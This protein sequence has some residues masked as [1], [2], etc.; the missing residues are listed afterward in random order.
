MAY[1]RQ[2]TGTYTNAILTI[3]FVLIVSLI[4]PLLARRET[5]RLAAVAKAEALRLEGAGEMGNMAVSAAE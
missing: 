4:V 3:G 1:I 5:I 2:T